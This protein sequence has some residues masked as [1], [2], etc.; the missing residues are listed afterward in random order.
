[1]RNSRS[2]GFSPQTVDRAKQV[3]YRMLS[4]RDRSVKE[5]ETKL[6]EK[7]FSEEVTA[8][9]VSFLKEAHYL[10]DDRFA[11]EWVRSRAVHRH[12]GPLRLKR[13]L[14][15]KGLSSGEADQSI[16]RLTREYDLLEQAETLLR[17]RWKDPAFLSDL[18]NKQRAY[19]FLQRKGF[20]GE[21]ILKAIR[22]IKSQ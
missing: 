13:E 19:L 11:W 2:T 22:K 1:M 20:D 10:D 9:V 3:A 4:Y 21:T 17:R 8:E 15:E 16:A 14:L 18:K 12:I 7:G 5:I 6:A